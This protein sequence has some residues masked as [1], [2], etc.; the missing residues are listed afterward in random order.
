MPEEAKRSPRSLDRATSACAFVHRWTFSTGAEG[1]LEAVTSAQPTPY[2][3]PVG[4]VYF[5]LASNAHALVAGGPIG[6]VRARMKVSSLLH[7]RVLLEAGQMIIQAGPTGSSAFRH[8]S[9]PGAP[10]TW[11]TPTARNRAQAMPFSLSMARETTPGIPAPGP[12]VPVLQSET[13]ICWIP[14]F[15]PFRNEL[16]PQCDWIIFGR[17]GDLPPPFEK[18]RDGWKRSD[19]RNAALNRL[20]RENFVRSRLV[21]HVSQ[22]LADGAAGGWDIS[23][24]RL[25]GRVIAARF[26][27][28]STLRAHGAALPLLI[29][30]VGDLAWE[31][32]VELRRH[33]AI[34]RLR[35]VLREVEAEAFEVAARDGDL[36]DAMRKAYTAKVSAAV[37]DVRVIRSTAA[38]VVAELAVG[39]ATGYATTGLAVLG[40]IAGA[41]MTA[42]VIGSWHARSL[43][44]ERRQRSW[45]GVMGAISAATP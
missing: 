15:E 42:G 25:H 29:P 5:P 10:A 20:V 12:Y 11:Q 6:S 37:D 33:R 40:P 8:G 38:H 31:D 13:S 22:N 39:A 3:A 1:E 19:D 4:E 27:D 44:R 43:I 34:Q 28:D 9:R 7:K 35:E 14:T 24:D 41:A 16:P 23:V 26:A 17:P 45:I 36:E 30:R 2:V 21:E 18:L 32:I